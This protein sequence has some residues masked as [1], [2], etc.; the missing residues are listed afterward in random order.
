MAPFSYLVQITD[1]GSTPPA[2]TNKQNPNL[3]RM[4]FFLPERPVL[5][6]FPG[7]GS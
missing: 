5:A 2:S 4:G 7:L 1:A 6:R 3:Y